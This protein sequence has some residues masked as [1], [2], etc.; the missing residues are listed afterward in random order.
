MTIY[1]LQLLI[2]SRLVVTFWFSWIFFHCSLRYNIHIHTSVYILYSLLHLELN[3]S[4]F[5]VFFF[6]RHHLATKK[7]IIYKIKLLF[8]ICITVS[9]RF[10]NFYKIHT[11]IASWMYVGM[12][13]CEGKKVSGHF[14]LCILYIQLHTYV[15]F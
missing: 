5:S 13:M 8:S 3:I 14:N 10:Q 1:A 11:M 4:R 2:S 6:I 12:Y 15:P 7:K 9:F